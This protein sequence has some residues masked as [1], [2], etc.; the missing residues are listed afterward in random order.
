MH[1]YKIECPQHQSIVKTIQSAHGVQQ[2][3]HLF[4]SE[5]RECVVRGFDCPLKD[6][7]IPCFLA[8]QL[9][10]GS[11]IDLLRICERNANIRA[12]HLPWWCW[13]IILLSVGNHRRRGIVH[14]MTGWRCVYHSWNLYSGMVVSAFAPIP[15]K[16]FSVVTR[17][18]VAAILL[19]AIWANEHIG[20]GICL[21]LF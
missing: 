4:G 21:A 6:W 8:D 16:Q 2:T 18:G 19:T 3:Y 20:K 12:D 10:S 9:I 11:Y 15:V 14:S 5:P 7:L 1:L 13:V 17:T